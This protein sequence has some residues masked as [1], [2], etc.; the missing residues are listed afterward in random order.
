MT[1]ESEVRG[2]RAPAFGV[3]AMVIMSEAWILRLVTGR[4]KMAHS[5]LAPAARL[6]ESPLET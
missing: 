4:G 6:K 3:R 2:L 1:G 5:C